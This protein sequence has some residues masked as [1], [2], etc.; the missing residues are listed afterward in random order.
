MF[1]EMFFKPEALNRKRTFPDLR[2]SYIKEIRMKYNA[3][4]FFLS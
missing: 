3:S 2:T 1:T 4:T